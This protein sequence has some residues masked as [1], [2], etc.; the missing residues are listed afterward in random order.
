MNLD[1]YIHKYLLETDMWYRA[2][3]DNTQ[4]EYLMK[5]KKTLYGLRLSLEYLIDK[6]IRRIV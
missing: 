6:Y 3:S 5:Y 2:M 4:S 1:E